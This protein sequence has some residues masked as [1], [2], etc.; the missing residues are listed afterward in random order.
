MQPSLDRIPIDI[1][2]L[3]TADTWCKWYRL[4]KAVALFL[5][6]RATIAILPEA[7]QEP[8]M[9]RPFDWKQFRFRRVYL[10]GAHN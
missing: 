9:R 4:P 1:K 7:T 5:H 10:G 8:R 2:W 3:M 6:V